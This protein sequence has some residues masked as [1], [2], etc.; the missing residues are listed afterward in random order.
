M[1]YRHQFF[2]EIFIITAWK[3]EN[4]EMHKSPEELK[5]HSHVGK[6]VVHTIMI[7]R[8]RFYPIVFTLKGG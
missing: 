3:F 6:L 1:E 2:I 7:Q 8:D 4:I 5:L